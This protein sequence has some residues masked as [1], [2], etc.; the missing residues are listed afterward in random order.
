MKNL[1]RKVYMVA[2]YNTIAMGTGRKEFNPKKERPELEEYIKEAGQGVLKQIGGAKNVDECVIGN[3]MASR[4]NMQALAPLPTLLISMVYVHHATIP[5][6]YPTLSVL[7]VTME[8][9]YSRVPG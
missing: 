9:R 8:C 6:A 3:F 5:T 4:Y 7:I 1:R 2:G